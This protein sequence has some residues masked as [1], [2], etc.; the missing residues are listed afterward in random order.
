[1]HEWRYKRNLKP[2]LLPA[3]R[4][5]RG[6]G[7]DLGKR[8]SEL[9]CGFNQRRALQRPLSR[10]APEACGLFDQAGLGAVTRQQLRL[11]LGDIRELALE[12]FGDTG[13]K[14]ASRLAQQR[15]IGGVPYQGMLE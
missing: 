14:R 1:M 4:R 3:Q 10:F 8:T 9:L 13:V 2:Y 6:Q 12:C 5:S 7:R 11:T 15:A